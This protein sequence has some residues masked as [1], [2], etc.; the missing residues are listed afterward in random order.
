MRQ[1]AIVVVLL[2]AASFAAAAENAAPKSDVG[3]LKSDIKNEEAIRKVYEQ[4]T[5]AWNKHDVAALTSGWAEDGDHVEPDG[6]VAKGRDQ[7]IALFTKEHATIF[8]DSHL[9]LNIDSVW[10]ITQDVALIDGT[11]ELDGVVLPDGTKIPPRKGRLSTNLLN[12][13]GRWWIVASRLMI[14]TVLP[15]KPST[16]KS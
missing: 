9:T 11:Y 13:Q 5:A 7:V 14:P 3:K 10:F 6:R 4:F 2:C 1:L 12:E 8:K 16:P 15:Y